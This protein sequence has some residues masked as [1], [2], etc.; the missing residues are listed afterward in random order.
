MKKINCK[1]KKTAV[2]IICAIVSLS[3]FTNAVYASIIEDVGSRM[4]PVKN[5]YG[6]D[7]G[8]I[9]PAKVVSQIISYVLSFLGVIFICL[10]IY[11]GFLWMTASGDSEQITK[12]KGIL[13][14][15]VIGVIIIL[16]A[17]IITS[18]ILTRL[19]SATGTG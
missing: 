1:I 13:I 19:G 10:I 16:S 8:E 11:A 4:S 3:I 17:Y 2:F 15:A 18:Y 7:Y 9:K 5:V 12:A 6:G 14:N